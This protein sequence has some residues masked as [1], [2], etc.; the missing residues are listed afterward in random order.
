MSQ[1]TTT[2]GVIKLYL[3][4]SGI[5]TALLHIEYS[6]VSLVAYSVVATLAVAIAVDSLNSDL[7]P[8]HNAAGWTCR[9]RHLLLLGMAGAQMSLLYDAVVTYEFGPEALRYAFDGLLSAALAVS[10]MKHRLR[11]RSDAEPSRSSTDPAA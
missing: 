1:H 9:Q 7:L 3:A 8:E 11:S 4:F 10:D 5:W 6:A 2:Q